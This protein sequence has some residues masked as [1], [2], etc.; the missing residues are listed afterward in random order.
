MSGTKLLQGLLGRVVFFIGVFSV[1]TIV[2][3]GCGPSE[4]GETFDDVDAGPLPDN[5][6]GETPIDAG[7]E[8]PIDPHVDKD[9][10]GWTPAQG[11]CDDNDPTVYPGAPIVCN[12][13]KDN[14]CNGFIDDAEPDMDGD[15]YPPC[16]NGQVYDCDD[17]DPNVHP[18]M[19]EIPGDGIDNNCDG[20]T[21]GD[22]DGDG[23][24]V[25]DGDCDDF[26]PNV[27]PGAPIVCNDGKDNNCNGFIDDDE[28][29]MDGDGYPPCKNG[30]VYDCD[31]TDPNIHP[32]MPEI[33]GDGI[34]NNCSGLTD[35]DI[36][37]DGWTVANGDCDD[38][39]ATVYPGAPIICNDGKD[40]NCNGFI[41]DDEP[42]M[43]GDGYP[44]C[45]NGMV[46]DCDD[47]N[48]YINP[49]AVEIPGDGID[50]N[51]NG[52][53]D[54]P[55]MACD[56]GNPSLVEAMELCEP[57]FV[58][59]VQTYGDAR[60]WTVFQSY[61]A[62]A[63]RTSLSHSAEGLLDVNCSAVMLCTGE[64]LDTNPQPG[65]SFGNSDPHPL[66]GNTANDLGQIIM[67]LQIPT[68]VEG[69]SFDFMF[70]SSEYP[71][72]VCTQYND[73]FLAILED[74]G[75]NGGQPTNI[76][77]DGNNNEITVNNNF[78]ENPN[79]WTESLA[80]TGYDAPDSGAICHGSSG[81]GCVMPSPCPPANNTIGSGTGWLRTIAPVTRNEVVTLTFSI[82][83][84][85]DNI[86]DSC[87]I[88]DNFQWITTPVEEP[89]TIK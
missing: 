58:L 57:Q 18:G 61:G 68:N 7:N 70:L 48:P 20:I 39:D 88:I 86:Y 75:L 51:C 52:L 69:I 82:H 50:N 13:G 76:S 83:D 1:I 80:G 72:W 23:W 22:F 55:R 42:D 67:T 59:D 26:D 87:V 85:G 41:D 15:G 8:D 84:E 31:D 37:G 65:T 53:T 6:G 74:P 3:V 16:R 60:Q 62:L 28:P 81:G 78:F 19:P 10:D 49:G 11:D 9:G 29:D 2:G 5:G 66:G 46:Y 71:E 4:S 14:N 38:F 89:E 21:D 33:P 73:A 45:K 35:E 30:M 56:C 27:Y 24:T 32:G 77:F 17:N 64:A 63:P 54:E 25:E 47:T 79:N 34:D 12:D 44:P 40:N 43:D 36:D